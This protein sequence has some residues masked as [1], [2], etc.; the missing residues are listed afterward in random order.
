MEEK[1]ESW[2]SEKRNVLIMDLFRLEKRNVVR[3]FLYSL[4]LPQVWWY[5]LFFYVGEQNLMKDQ[6]KVEAFTVFRSHLILHNKPRHWRTST[7]IVMIQLLQ[8][9]GWDT[10]FTLVW[11]LTV[12]KSATETHLDAAWLLPQFHILDFYIGSKCHFLRRKV[13]AA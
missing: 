3:S 7:L 5:F 1:R 6:R 12:L 11:L 13:A 4:S 8:I 9:C 10:E 2:S